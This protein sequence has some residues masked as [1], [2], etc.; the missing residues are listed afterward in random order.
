MQSESSSA[1][2]RD[3][4]QQRPVATLASKVRNSLRAETERN[5]GLQL[6]PKVAPSLTEP[7]PIGKLPAV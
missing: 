3:T 7:R 4:Y 6:V 1:H 2:K 5:L